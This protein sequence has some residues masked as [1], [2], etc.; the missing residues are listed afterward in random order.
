MDTTP[1]M[2]AQGRSALGGVLRRPGRAEAP[3]ND[4]VESSGAF[5]KGARATPAKRAVHEPP[6]RSRKTRKIGRGFPTERGGTEAARKAAPATP[7]SRTDRSP[8]PPGR[9]LGACPFVVA[10]RFSPLSPEA[11]ASGIRAKRAVHEPPLRSRKTRKIG[12]AFPTERVGTQ[13]ARKAADL[14]RS[15]RSL[16]AVGARVLK[17]RSFT[18]RPRPGRS[19]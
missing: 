17:V 5:A 14:C 8:W 1:A 2:E 3:Q 9:S 19:G 10:R 7:V 11:P 13:T 18:S 12:R 15:G 16:N 6:L 4:G